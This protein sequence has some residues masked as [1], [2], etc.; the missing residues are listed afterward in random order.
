MG[1]WV[2]FGVAAVAIALAAWAVVRAIRGDNSNQGAEIS[3]VHV[4][5][6]G[7]NPADE[8]LIVA[9]HH[10]SFRVEPGDHD[11]TWLPSE[12]P[13]LLALSWQP[14]GALWA[15]DANGSLWNL[16]ESEW[17]R[18]GELPGAPQAL[19]A[20]PTDL[21]VAVVNDAGASGLYESGDGG[22]SWES[23]TH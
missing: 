7:L 2:S 22:Q 4:H 3:H 18:V 1:D 13:D 16:S 17:A 14:D 19:L 6:L 10:G 12:G 23:I 5:G 8:S 9:T 15:A 21:Y 20:T 11:R